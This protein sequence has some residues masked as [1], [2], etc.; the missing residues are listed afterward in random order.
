MRRNTNQKPYKKQTIFQSLQKF[1][2]SYGTQT[3]IT[4]F[5]FLS[6]IHPV[7][8]STPPMTFYL[9]PILCP[10]GFPTRTTLACLFP[11]ACLMP[12]PSQP[13]WKIKHVRKTEHE[14]ALYAFSF[15]SCYFLHRKSTFLPQHPVCEKFKPI[16]SLNISNQVSHSY[17]TTGNTYFCIF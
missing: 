4:M 1:P 10:P 12:G 14:A 5:T 6:Q 8:Q 13:H 16:S 2:V 7:I 11:R 15:D 17:E 3:F 9:R